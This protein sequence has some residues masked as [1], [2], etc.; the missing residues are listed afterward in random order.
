ME[1]TPLCKSLYQQFG[2]T[3]MNPGPTSVNINV[4]QCIIGFMALS[5]AVTSTAGLVNE[6]TQKN[7]KDDV[8]NFNVCCLVSR[9]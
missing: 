7:E 1:L 5:S 4:S 2:Q 3:Q 6:A 8:G 9:F